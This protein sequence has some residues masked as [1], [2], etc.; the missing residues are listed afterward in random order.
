MARRPPN[1]S[2]RSCPWRARICFTSSEWAD[3]VIETSLGARTG[4][5]GDLRSHLRQDV[6]LIGQNDDLTAALHAELAACKGRAHVQP[7]L[8]GCLL[9]FT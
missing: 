3:E 8:H 6:L 7:D 1:S 5:G 4:A 9:D 2:T